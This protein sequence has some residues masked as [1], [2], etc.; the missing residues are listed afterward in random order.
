MPNVLQWLSSDKPK[1]YRVF[2]LLG[3]NHT[4][5]SDVLDGVRRVVDP[6]EVESFFLGSGE[7]DASPAQ[8]WD[9]VTTQPMPGVKRRLVI[10]RD[11]HRIRNWRP[12]DAFIAGAAS[13][14]ETSLVLVLDRDQL[15]KR[16]R[17][18]EKSL[19]GAPVWETVYEPWEQSLKNYASCGVFV[20]SELSLEAADRTK[21]SQAQRWLSMRLPLSQR[22][23]EYLWT[24]VGESPLLARD[25]LRGLEL[26]GLRDAS[27]LSFSDFMAYVN[28]LVSVHGATD[29]VDHLL[30]D[31]KLEA[32][33]A[34]QSS[35]FSAGDYRKI[36]GLLAQR[37]DWLHALHGALAT[38]EH[39]DQ[40]VR[41]L[42]I[43]RHM[44]L[45]YAH[46]D[47]AKNN[48]ARKYDL[49]RVVRVRSLL[50]DFDAR[51]SASPVVPVGFGES[52]IVAWG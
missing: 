41:R 50:A 48:I 7:G 5:R 17:N 43:P 24:R 11:A 49:R 25:V 23:T 42:G 13:Y 45:Y 51:L 20:C 2:V 8:V 6:Q 36:L 38:N 26:I 33:S 30:F 29:F 4:L 37:V 40:V 10:V 1:K 22:Q 3:S 31:R 35:G 46:R 16:E 21:P 47:V 52:L 34:V 14:P 19:P 9:S 18:R 15:G 32:F 27:L 28:A 44:V 39:L 12:L